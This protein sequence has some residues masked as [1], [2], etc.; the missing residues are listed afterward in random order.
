MCM[1]YLVPIIPN[2]LFK[3]EHPDEVELRS[4]TTGAPTTPGF[5][6]IPNNCRLETPADWQTTRQGNGGR[7]WSAVA[8]ESYVR[9]RPRSRYKCLNTTDED[10]LQRW[11]QQ[12]GP[13]SENDDYNDNYDDNYDDEY[14][15]AD[16][17]MA[18][19]EGA[20]TPDYA[21]YNE[22]IS[23]EDRHRDIMNENMVVGL[24]F[25]SKAI[26]QLIT[27]PFVGP[28]TNRFDQQLMVY[29]RAMHHSAKRGIA[30]ACRPSVRP[31]VRLSVTLADQKHLRWKSWKLIARTIAQHLRSS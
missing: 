31:S 15:E 19:E 4:T 20:T 8:A 23:Q 7:R 22:T 9:G 5:A 3:L 16:E 12:E 21:E 17:E 1:Y 18:D 29:Y 25:A 14:E 28:I 26:M 2:F 30:I 27:N 10:R 6:R 13:A 11:L 24:M